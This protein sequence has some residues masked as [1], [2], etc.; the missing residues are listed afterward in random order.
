MMGVQQYSITQSIYQNWKSWFY[1]VIKNNN[2][3][4]SE[5]TPESSEAIN[6]NIKYFQKL[7]IINLASKTGK[8]NRE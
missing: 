3:K 5:I 2:K 1:G 6:E 7:K 8:S 4:G